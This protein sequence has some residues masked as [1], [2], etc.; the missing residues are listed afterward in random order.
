MQLIKKMFID[1]ILLGFLDILLIS[2]NRKHLNGQACPHLNISSHL[3]STFTRDLF[4]FAP[5]LVEAVMEYKFGDT[6]ATSW[7][8]C[9][10][11]RILSRNK[12]PTNL[13]EFHGVFTSTLNTN[14]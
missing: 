11:S 13:Y 9:K 6:V 5:T 3:I 8:S 10:L 2:A 14:S 12:F 7:N 1:R 4:S